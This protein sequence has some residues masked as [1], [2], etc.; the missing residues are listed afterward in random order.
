[1]E[2]KNDNPAGRLYDIL[3][4]V[5]VQPQ[6]SALGE[7]LSAALNASNPVDFHKRLVYLKELVAEVRQAV[8]NL[9]GINKDLYL[10]HYNQIENLVN[11]RNYDM[12][13]NNVSNLLNEPTLINIA[14]IAE[15]LPPTYRENLIEDDVLNDL[16]FTIEGLIKR[17][18]EGDLI[19]ELQRII[20]DQLYLTLNSIYAYKIRG[21]RGLREALSSSLG[22]FIL[23]YKLFEDAKDSEEVKEYKSILTKTHTIVTGAFTYYQIAQEGIKQ[24]LG[25]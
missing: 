18:K 22:E 19:I 2:V 25:N 15:I 5:K 3:S 4:K 20:I 10:S 21:A 13:W 7:V 1:V 12:P 14:H 6:Q 17:V 11:A 23:N 24:L 16:I 9:E 8:E